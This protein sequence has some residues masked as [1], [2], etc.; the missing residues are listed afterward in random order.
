MLITTSRNAKSKTKEFAKNLA[1]SLPYATYKARSVNTMESVI[2]A[3]EFEA[4]QKI[5]V[6]LDDAIEV[7]DLEGKLLSSYKISFLVKGKL[8]KQ[9]LVRKLPEEIKFLEEKF[10]LFEEYLH[11]QSDGFFEVSGKKVEYF[12]NEK[13]IFEFE[14]VWMRKFYLR[15]FLEVNSEDANIVL[16]SVMVENV[17]QKRSEV[18]LDLCDFGLELII[19]ADDATA[20]RASYNSFMLAINSAL[21]VIEW[22]FLEEW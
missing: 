7:F 13:E 17:K 12:L 21:S 9:S 14:M 16:Q 18:K 4:A 6:V 15:Q 20:L 5:L 11:D 3:A 1:S 10:D 2:Q 8:K 22:Y 19:K